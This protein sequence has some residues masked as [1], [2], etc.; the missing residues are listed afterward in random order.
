MSV[1]VS[2]SVSVSVRLTK[3]DFRGIQH[4]FI[5]KQLEEGVSYYNL[6]FNDFERVSENF[7]GLNFLDTEL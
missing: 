7:R 6:S 2:V 1:N 4:S 3:H 5:T